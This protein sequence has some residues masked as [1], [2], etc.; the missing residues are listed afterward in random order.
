MCIN[1]KE[2]DMLHLCDMSIIRT[3]V[4]GRD[5]TRVNMVNKI[6]STF[7][8]LSVSFYFFCT[9]CNSRQCVVTMLYML[10]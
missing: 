9:V 3:Q 8:N 4:S 1:T 5:Q 2:Y 6:C 10:C 7:Y